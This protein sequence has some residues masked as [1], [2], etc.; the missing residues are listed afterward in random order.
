MLRTQ[1]YLPQNQISRLKTMADIKKTTMSAVL[2][3][4]LSQ[5]LDNDWNKKLRPQIGLVKMAKR[6][7]MLREKGPK[8]L[9]SKADNYL[10]GGK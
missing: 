9:S 4:I 10:Y 8:D 2:R 7:S 1:I 5:E 6:A 3:L